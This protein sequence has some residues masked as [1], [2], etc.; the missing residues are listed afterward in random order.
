M[1]ATATPRTPCVP[2]SPLLVDGADIIA[3]VNG[4]PKLN[5]LAYNGALLTSNNIGGLTAYFAA[6]SLAPGLY[7]VQTFW[8][9]G[10]GRPVDLIHE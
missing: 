5:I 7:D 3:S 2:G 10:T 6:T 4:L 8:P 9:A 1:A